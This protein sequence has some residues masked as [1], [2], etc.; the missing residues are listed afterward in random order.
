MLDADEAIVALGRSG[1]ARIQARLSR[2]S[3]AM[4]SAKSA[5]RYGPF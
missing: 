2:K 3:V 5:R 1:R 4:P